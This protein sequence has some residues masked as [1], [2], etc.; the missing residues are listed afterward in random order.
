MD[1]YKK[2]YYDRI[3]HSLGDY[4][5]ISGR[6]QL[7]QDL[8][9][10]SFQWYLDNI[11]PELFI[12][13]DSIASGT[14]KNPW[15]NKC[16]DSPAKPANYHKPVGLYPCHT[17]GGNQYWMLSKNNEVRRDEACLD[18]TG[19]EVILY[20]CHGGRGNQHWNYD[21]ARSSLT[22]GA[23]GNRCLTISEQRNRLTVEQCDRGSERQRWTF[24][25]PPCFGPNGIN[26]G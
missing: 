10:K 19:K 23:S 26:C 13:G 3:G 8:N 21:H 18:F 17:Q 1:D 24:D 6:K 16:L 15:S 5:D 11:Y 7:R 14:L 9:C 25:S 20:P 12:P 2:Y 4:G 22:H